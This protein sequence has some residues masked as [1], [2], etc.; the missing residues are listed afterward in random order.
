MS[1]NTFVLLTVLLAGCAG[2]HEGGQGGAQNPSEY[3]RSQGIAEGTDG[4]RNCVS[5]YIHQ[6][7]MSQGL[8]LGTEEYASC[9]ASLRN[10]SFLRQQM[11][12][13]GR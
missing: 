11:Q 6:Y 8:T 9:E 2:T 4:F 10:A 3:C 7:C 12:I 5:N 1:R 13:R